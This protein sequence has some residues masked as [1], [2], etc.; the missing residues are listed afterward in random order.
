MERLIP[1]IKKCGVADVALIKYEDCEIINERLASNI[2]FVPKSV[3]ICTIPYY[4]KFCNEKK[5]VSAY[6][7]AYDYHTLLG[8]IDLALATTVSPI[9]CINVW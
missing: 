2:G 8:N 3:Y 7:L 5:T 4:T 1:E 6:A 9:F